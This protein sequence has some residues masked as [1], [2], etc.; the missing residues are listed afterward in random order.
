MLKFNVTDVE[1]TTHDV[2]ALGDDEH[3]VVA[4]CR[5]GKF[6]VRLVSME[7]GIAMARKEGGLPV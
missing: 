1:I 7:Q 6:V 5:G 3:A 2:M 4:D